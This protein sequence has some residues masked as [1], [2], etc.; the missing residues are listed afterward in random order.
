MSGWPPELAAVIDFTASAGEYPEI[1]DVL[2]RPRQLLV[3]DQ[4]ASGRARAEFAAYE[5]TGYLIT[6]VTT[7][8]APDG[9]LVAYWAL[10][11]PPV[12]IP[13]LL[14][15]RLS[16][17]A[18]LAAVALDHVQLIDR[19]RRE[20][21]EDPL[22]GL[23]TRSA[24]QRAL[25]ASLSRSGSSTTAIVYGD[26]DHFKR[27]NDSI[28]HPGGDELLRQVAVERLK[29]VARSTDTLARPGGDEFVALLPDVRHD[30]DVEGFV[31]RI[32][33]SLQAPFHIGENKLYTTIST[34]WA[35]SRSTEPALQEEAA[36]ALLKA[37]DSR[38]YQA[39]QRRRVHPNAD[40]PLD[41]LAL[42]TDL[43]DAVENGDIR[44]YFQPQY[45][46]RSGLLN[47]YEALARWQHP[48]HGPVPPSVFVP[49]AEDNGSHP[50]HR[51]ADARTGL[52]VRRQ[53]EQPPL[54]CLPD[55]GQR[56]HPRTRPPA[57]RRQSSRRLN[58]WSH[59]TWGLRLEV[60]E[61]ALIIDLA[62]VQHALLELRA[63]GIGIAIDDFGSGYSS[64]SQLQEL[65]ATE[66]KI[67]KTFIHR[68]GVVGISLTR[69]I[70]ALG[71]SLNLEL[72]AEGIETQNQLDTLRQLG[73]DRLQGF[74]LAPP[75]ESDAALTAP[76]TIEEALS[77]ALND[78]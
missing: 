15:E 4:S 35:T 14:A 61:S 59:P 69:A 41:G 30:S 27:V 72:V 34:G 54:A 12:E 56:L 70:I 5:M 46:A 25:A 68:G 63:H 42:D 8:S 73:C 2:T 66:L 13:K 18:G 22:T 51:L 58:R 45:D 47:G 9:L 39:K 20:A 11:P 26:L 24:L 74:L 48:R 75:L 21:D 19:I 16:G 37:A 55:A 10:T 36:I 76:R 71:R 3:T 50:Q 44:A 23:A 29:A 40:A 17:I 60:T 57:L 53:G 1:A 7:E 49:L 64:L 62:R 52:P 28:G 65:P 32:H 6:P 43:H 38:M 33:Q 78:Q 77:H 67:D 31:E